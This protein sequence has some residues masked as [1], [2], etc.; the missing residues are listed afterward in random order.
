MKEFDKT[1]E[2]KQAIVDGARL[3]LLAAIIDMHGQAT[4]LAPVRTGN[5]RGSLSWTVGGQVGGITAPA[6]SSDGVGA[7]NDEDTAYLGTNVEYGPALEYGHDQRPQPYLR[8]ALDMR[9]DDAGKMI[10]D[11]VKKAIREVAP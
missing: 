8:P 9:R 4:L 2:V 1:E 3:G 5:L 7:T 10:N 6:S 11:A